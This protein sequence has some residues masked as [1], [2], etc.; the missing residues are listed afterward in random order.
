MRWRGVVRKCTFA[1][2]IKLLIPLSES[3]FILTISMNRIVRIHEEQLV[4]IFFSII[5]SKI[6]MA[7]HAINYYF[8][9]LQHT[10]DLPKVS[11]KNK[12]TTGKKIKRSK[13]ANDHVTSCGLKEIASEIIKNI[14]VVTKNGTFESKKDNTEEIIINIEKEVNTKKDAGDVNDMEQSNVTTDNSKVEKYFANKSDSKNEVQKISDEVNVKLNTHTMASNED[15][16]NNLVVEP[17]T[18]NDSLALLN[19]GSILSQNIIIKYDSDTPDINDEVLNDDVPPKKQKLSNET[20]FTTNDN[21]K[22]I[23][24]SDDVFSMCTIP[25]DNKSEN[26]VNNHDVKSDIVDLETNNIKNSDNVLST[27]ADLPTNE[28]NSKME[29]DDLNCIKNELDDI[30]NVS[31]N[32]E[33]GSKLEGVELKMKQMEELAM[34]K[35]KG[36]VL[37]NIF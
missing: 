11:R 24:A 14:P 19:S 36:S 27:A 13:P 6:A 30:I 31:E 21:N 32:N 4:L 5:H 20:D 33:T 29:R 25:S 12:D 34:K 9:F 16:E 35:F 10:A 37:D 23:P 8:T 28:L 1:H 7:W 17:N 15:I 26:K 18:Q 22:K 3:S 2:T